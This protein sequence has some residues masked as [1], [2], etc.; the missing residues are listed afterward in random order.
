MKVGVSVVSVVVVMLGWNLDDILLIFFDK[1]FWK[2][3][4]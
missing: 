2:S 1:K 4:C 3:G